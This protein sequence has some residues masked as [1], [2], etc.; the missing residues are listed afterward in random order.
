VVTYRTSRIINFA[1]GETGMLAAFAYFDIRLGSNTSTFTHDHGVLLALPMALVLGAVIGLAME[2]G[3]R[4]SAQAQPDAQRDGRDDRASLLFLTYATHPLGHRGQATKPL[5][6]GHG[7][8]VV[9]LT[10]SP[11][12]LLIGAC[13]LAI[14]AGLTA[15]F[16]TPR[17]VAVPGDRVNRYGAPCRVNTNATSMV[18]WH[19]R[20]VCRR[21]RVCSSPRSWRSTSS[22]M[23]LLALRAF[24][25]PLVRRPHQHLGRFPRG[26]YSAVRR[27][28]GVQSHRRITD[29]VRR[30]GSSSSSSP[31]RRSGPCPY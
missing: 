18:T 19:R 10:I 20:R 29:V 26:S 5:I 4:P 25:P 7:V 9:G 8:R 6:E 1:Y 28:R 3:D 2:V 11:S 27:S 21:C 23:T 24:A 13:S 16:R 22:F 17:S 31:A 12:Q 30:L 15:L 14:L